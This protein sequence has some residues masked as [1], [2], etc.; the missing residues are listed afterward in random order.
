MLQAP[1]DNVFVEI[2][3]RYDD[4]IHFNS[5]VKLYV[6]PSFNPNF[7]ATVEGIVHSVPVNLRHSNAKINPIIRPGDTVLFSYKTVGD[8]TFQDN[9]HLFRMTTKEE[10]YFTTWM[11]QERDTIRLEKGL[12][13]NQWVAIYTDKRGDLV[14]GRTGNHGECEGWIS[15]NFK[16][17]DGEGFTY[18]NRFYYDDKEL[19]KVDYSLIFAIR[20]N[21]HMRM[22]GDYL[23]FEPIVENRPELIGKST[24]IRTEGDRM[25]IREDKGWL[26]C[27]ARGREGMRE[28]DVLLFDANMK[29]KYNVEGHPVYIVKRQY[30]IGKEL[31]ASGIESLSLN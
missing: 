4:E 23:L 14:A 8:I 5:G 24:L 1:F 6:D 3:A 26:R 18:D 7:H 2:K 11:N 21:G 9:T 25:C 28:G 22:T 31:G 15:S 19:W 29:E 12:K 17:A 27:G 13:D 20:R 10:G 30:V 16:F